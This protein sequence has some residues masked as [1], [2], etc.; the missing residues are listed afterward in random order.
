M[1]PKSIKYK[2]CKNCK[3]IYKDKSQCPL[4][5]SS[6]S[7]NIWRGVIFVFDHSK[8]QITKKLGINDNG[9]FALKVK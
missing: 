3:F 5:K 9:R 4:C 6:Q 7:S 2:A 1:T 8:S